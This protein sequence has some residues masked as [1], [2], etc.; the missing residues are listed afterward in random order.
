[1]SD[2]AEITKTKIPETAKNDHRFLD[3]S[4]DTTFY[5]KS[6]KVVVG[7][8]GVSLAFSI[9]MAKINADLCIVRQQIVE[10]QNQV[11]ADRYLNVIPSIKKKIAQGSFFF[12]ASDD[13]PEVRQILY[14]YLSTLDCT[15]EVV[16]GRKLPSLFATKHNNKESEFY[17]DLLSHLIKNK[18][19]LGSKLI[20]NVAH[21]ANSTSNSNLQLAL[22][23][24]VGRAAKKCSPEELKTTVV[25]NVQNHR[26]EPL[27]NIVDYMCWSVQRV[28]ERGETRHYD[29]I[30]EKISLVVDL[31]DA[32]NYEGSR[33]YYRKDRPLGAT[34]KLSPPSP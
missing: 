21:R 30:G 13:P 27:L 19:K 4:G 12:H 17:A 5:G 3:E 10:L 31:Y 29:F 2:D 24:A 26:T 16:V 11:A 33:N 1:M 9:G 22:A 6:R 32:A 18:L 15:L 20:L 23:K 7:Q 28:F 25:F 8:Q 34:N 14:K